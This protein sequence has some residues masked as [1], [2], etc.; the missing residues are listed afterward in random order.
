[1]TEEEEA[2][3]EA[4]ETAEGGLEM[5]GGARCCAV[6]VNRGGSEVR[7]RLVVTAVAGDDA[8]AMGALALRCDLT[9]ADASPLSPQTPWIQLSMWARLQAGA[10]DCWRPRP[11][12]GSSSE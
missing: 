2:S 5:A 12:R 6:S 4:E 8:T 10:V 9:V 7:V 3:D 11:A 1:M